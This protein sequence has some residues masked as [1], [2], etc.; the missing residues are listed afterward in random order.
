MRA[1]AREINI[2]QMGK[3]KIENVIIT[4]RNLSMH[5]FFKHLHLLTI[6]LLNSKLAYRMKGTKAINGP[7][8]I[9]R[10]QNK[11]STD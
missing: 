6:E 11:M 10:K 4:K 9:N 7:M 5:P 2:K 3:Q 8:M 1:A